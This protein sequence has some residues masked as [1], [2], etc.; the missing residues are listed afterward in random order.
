[1]SLCVLHV[2]KYYPPA[3]GG[4]ES[5]LADLIQEQRA[6]GIDA[7]AL[8]HGDPLPED[9]NWLRRVPVQMSLI[10]APIAVGFR[11]AFALAIEE[12][13][14]DVLHLHMPNNAVFWALT[15]PRARQ[16]PW[17]VHWHSDVLVSPSQRLLFAHKRPKQKH[18]NWPA[19]GAFLTRKL[20][21][22]VA[23]WVIRQRG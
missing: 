17:V 22:S 7:N 1:M 4:M 2:G 8:V 23:H 18:R 9:P 3:R 15:L 19:T 5:F 20:L 13:R 6:Q 12:I 11:A 21:P 14:P 10:F 16:I